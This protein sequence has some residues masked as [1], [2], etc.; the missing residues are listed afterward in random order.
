MSLRV[1]A[2]VVEDARERET[3]R[4]EQCVADI[5]TVRRRDQ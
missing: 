3:D 1:V 5:V 4:S 2:G